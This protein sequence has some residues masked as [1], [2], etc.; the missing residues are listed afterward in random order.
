MYSVKQK[1]KELRRDLLTLHHY[2][3]AG[4][5]SDQDYERLRKALVMK[6][7]K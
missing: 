7:I 2:W 3:L 5:L 1:R 6:Y 4:R